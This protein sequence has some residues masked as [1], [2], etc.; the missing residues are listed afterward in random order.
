MA[1]YIQ[2]L[3]DYIPEI[4]PFQPDLKL[5]STALQT[6]QM[7]YDTNYKKLSDYYGKLLKSPML[8]DNNIQRRDEFIKNINNEIKKISGMDLSL[9]QNVSQAMNVLDP[10]IKD[11]NIVSDILATKQWMSQKEFG[12][13]AKGTVSGW[14][15]GLQILDYWAEE[16]KKVNDEDALTFRKPEF[17]PRVDWYA[18]AMD[19]AV[20]KKFNVKQDNISADGKWIVTN[21][22]GDLIAPSLQNYFIGRF[23]SDPQ[24]V[25]YFN[26]QAYLERKNFIRDNLGKYNDNEA[27]AQIAFAQEK[28]NDAV[29]GIKANKYKADDEKKAIDA[30][31]DAFEDFVSKSGVLPSDADIINMGKSLK[32][33]QN[34][35]NTSK[36]ALDGAYKTLELYMKDYDDFLS[37][38]NKLDYILGFRKMSNA[39]G[40][41][42][43]NYAY[44]NEERIIKGPNDYYLEGVKQSNRIALENLRFQHDLAKEEFKQNLKE[45]KEREKLGLD[46]LEQIENMPGANTPMNTSGLKE[47]MA[48]SNAL[49]ADVSQLKASLLSDAASNMVNSYENSNATNQ[50]AIRASLNNI[51]GPLGI[52]AEELLNPST[53][54]TALKKIAMLQQSTNPNLWSSYKSLL[55]NADPKN[56]QNN[57]WAENLRRD[58]NYWRTVNNINTQDKNLNNFMSDRMEQLKDVRRWFQNK[59]N[60]PTGIVSAILSESNNGFWPGSHR[61][62]AIINKLVAANEKKFGKNNVY[63]REY[64]LNN[65]ES[66]KKVWDNSLDK[67]PNYK[68]WNHIEG[69]GPNSNASATMG[70]AGYFNYSNRSK[71][72]HTNTFDA[73]LKDIGV[74]LASLPEIEDNVG[75]ALLVG[76]G[77]NASVLETSDA[78]AVEDLKLMLSTK[79]SYTDPKDKKV[80]AGRFEYANISQNDPNY[81]GVTIYPSQQFIEG[82]K[83]TK[84]SPRAI[85]GQ[86]ITVRIPRSIA[87]NP[88]Y[89]QST[90]SANE[91]SYERGGLELNYPSGKANIR[92]TSSGPVVDYT[93]KVYNTNRRDYDEKSY[94]QPYMDGTDIDGISDT[95]EAVLAKLYEINS[96]N[97]AN[98]RMVYG[99]KDIQQILGETAKA[100]MQENLLP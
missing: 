20:K 12:Q 52:K 2:G 27:L 77:N 25:K 32:Q 8:R 43:S 9:E 48:K 10:I 33:A 21:Q 23:G 78:K 80:F 38:G 70:V 30:L 85:S 29:E 61:K 35:A 42:A 93:L 74:G 91:Y 39:F 40:T 11:K 63:N 60:D 69:L 96:I 73:I 45:K 44:M 22:N 14:D 59:E 34:N 49:F 53:R 71:G 47:N 94:S 3:T 18:M 75:G 62:D 6:M 82:F 95:Y 7:K 64:F 76:Y 26:A 92:K 1:T 87:T 83:E 37:S 55:E 5:Y 46:Q 17:I 31:N 88:L 41:V 50:K 4:Q 65:W 51:Y 68:A 97:I 79:G 54:G 89:R 28:L 72:S 57:A 81:I 19:D 86:P 15:G 67:I 16:Y 98:D 66:A 84:D 90:T 13:N 58:P 24:V 100:T 56:V 36:D 99:M